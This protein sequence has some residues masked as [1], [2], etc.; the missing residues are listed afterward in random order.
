MIEA[1]IDAV[2]ALLLAKPR[3]KEF[4]ER[5]QRLDAIAENPIAPDVT[6]EAASAGNVPLEWSYAPGADPTRV[7][8]YFHG[9]GYCSGSIASHRGMV[10]EAGRAAQMRTLAVGYRLAPEHPFPAAIEDALTAYRFL[11]GQGI[12]PSA[13]ALGGDSAGGGLSLALMLRLH[14]EGEPLPACAW[15]VSPWVDLSMTGESLKT[16]ASADPLIQKDYLDELASAYLN[17]HDPGDPLVSPLKASLDGLPPLLI[18]A[19]SDETLLDD[20]TRIAARAGAADVAVTLE[21]WPHMIH[22]WPLW[23]DRLEEGRLALSSA[24]AYLKMRLDARKAE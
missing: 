12:I 22:A 3:P 6:I 24:G 21:I 11:L 9:G 20:A 10:V 23:A 18:Q 14:A 15:L 7:L 17:G 1:G 16:K 2:R 19:G 8:L 4:A 5:R 13:I